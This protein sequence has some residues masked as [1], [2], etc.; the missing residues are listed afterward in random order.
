MIPFV[1]KVGVRHRGRD[2]RLWIPLALVWLLL[3]PLLLLL[4]PLFLF[5]CLAGQVRPGHALSVF[6]DVLSSTRD[7]QIE[8][9]NASTSVSIYVF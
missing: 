6:W 5:V 1:A 7:S 3:L 8:F 4:S 2:I 9:G